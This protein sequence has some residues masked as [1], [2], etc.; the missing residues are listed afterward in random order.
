MTF[1]PSSDAPRLVRAAVYLLWAVL[2][3][4]VLL[5]F[6]FFDAQ[7]M[8]LAK[9]VWLM[10]IGLLL[11]GY[12]IMGIAKGRNSA[13]WLYPVLLLL[14]ALATPPELTDPFD[15]LPLVV[16]AGALIALFAG[17]ANRWFRRDK[18]GAA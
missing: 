17:G 14:G 4:G 8:T 16:Q 13:R 2:G 18:V 6:A 5:R 9:L 10:A 7:T 1:A 3:V 15:V 11:H 12:F